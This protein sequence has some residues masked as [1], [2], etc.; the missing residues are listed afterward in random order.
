MPRTG[1]PSS[2]RASQAAWQHPLVRAAGEMGLD[3][4][5]DHAPSAASSSDVFAEQLA[6]ATEAG[7]PVVI[8]AREADADIVA[9]LRNQADATDGPPLLLQ[10]PRPPGRRARGGV[11]LFLQ[12]HGDVQVVDPAGR[13]A[14]GGQR[15]DC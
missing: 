12:R 14:R 3:Y 11:V 13:H 7:M 4:H 10:R 5:Y 8:H 15:T 9:I 2:A 6:L 1:P